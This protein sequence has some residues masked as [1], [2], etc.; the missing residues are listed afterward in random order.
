VWKK[1]F[2]FKAIVYVGAL[3]CCFLNY[4]IISRENQTLYDKANSVG[5]IATPFRVVIPAEA[6]MTS[7]ETWGGCRY[8]ALRAMD[9]GFHRYDG[10]GSESFP[11]EVALP[12]M[13]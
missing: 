12:C 2:M 11:N 8:V 10:G 9:T 7:W 3:L 6:G 4:T 1:F 13:N 5:R